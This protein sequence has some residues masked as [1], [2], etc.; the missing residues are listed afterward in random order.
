MLHGEQAQRNG[1]H[2]WASQT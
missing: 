2:R 1:Q